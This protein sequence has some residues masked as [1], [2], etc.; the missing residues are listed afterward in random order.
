MHV[1]APFLLPRGAARTADMTAGA[2]CTAMTVV[3]GS[4]APTALGTLAMLRLACAVGA[5]SDL[6]GRVRNP[7]WEAEL[8][9][10]ERAAQAAA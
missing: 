5:G 7:A 9:K 10:G 3:V 1:G 6:I 8:D 4:R 2:A